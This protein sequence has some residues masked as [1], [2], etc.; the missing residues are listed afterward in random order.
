LPRGEVRGWKDKE[1]LSYP[2]ALSNRIAYLKDSRNLED[3]GDLEYRGSGNNSIGGSVHKKIILLT[4]FIMFSFAQTFAQIAPA[5]GIRKNTPAVHALKNLTIVVAPGKKIEKGTIIVRDG[6]IE[7]AGVNVAIPTDARVWDCAGLTAYAGLIDLYTDLGQPKPRGPGQP[8]PST[9]SPDPPRGS[10]HWNSQ[11]H[12]ELSGAE[13]FLPDKDAAEKFRA[14]GF[15]SVLS[16]PPNGILRGSSALVNLGEGTPNGQT[17]KDN[18]TEDISFSRDPMGDGYPS[19]LMGAIALIRQTFIDANWY[20]DAMRVYAK[21]P[22]QEKPEDDKSLAALEDAAVDKQ[23][24]VFETTDELNILR[25]AKIAREFSLSFWIRGN[26]YEYRR[27]DAVKETNAPIILPV[28]FPDPPNVNTSGEALDAGYEELRHWDFAPENPARMKQAGITFALTTSTLKDVS[29]FRTLVHTAIERGLKADDALASLTTIPAKLVGMEKQLGTLEAGKMANFVLAEGELFGEKTKIR[30]TWIDGVRY[31]VKSP[32]QVEA[33]G[34]WTCSVRIRATKQ[35]TGSLLI[36]GEPEALSGTIG[37]GALMLKITTLT[38]SGKNIALIYPGDSLGYPGVVRMTGIAE[39]S[40][41]T[42]SGELPDGSSF[43]WSARLRTP[44]V[45]PPDTTKKP[46]VQHA[47]FDVVYPEGAFGRKTLP[48][49]P[50]NILV[51]GGYVWTSGP[52]GNLENMDILYAN[53]KVAKIGKDL[54]A[55]KG[56]TIIDAR[57]KHVTA[58][59]IDCHSHTAISEGVNEAGQAI[60]AEVRIADVLDPTDIAIYRELAGGLT[61]ANLLHGSAN[62]IGGQNQVVKLRWGVLPD[63][64]KFEGAPE[65]IKFA[66]GENVKQSNW[67]DRYTTRYPQSRMGVEQIIRD[68]FRAAQDYGRKFEEARKNP[69]MI[70]PR[71]DLELDAIVEILKGTRLVHSHAYRQDEILMLIRIADDFGFTIATFQHVLEGYKIA[72]AIAKHGA[73]ASTFSDWWAYKYEVIDAIPYNGALMHDVGVVVSYNSD[74]DELARR[75]NTESAKG[76]KYG[77]VSEEEALK[78]VTINPAKQLGIDKRVGS[79]EVGKDADF[80]IWSGSPLSTYSMC[81]Q[82]WIDGRKYFDREED[83]VMNAGIQKE[84]AE[85]IQKILKAK[86]PGTGTGIPPMPPKKSSYSCHE[87]E[88]GAE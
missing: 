79:I 3:F 13:Q 12:P 76:V 64:M 69:N 2:I 19:S 74:S 88:G 71:R 50:E 75:L 27:L 17:I 85:L 42:G 82:T 29:K 16:S 67:G 83:R 86:K 45:Q 11:V 51:R 7:S 40:T 59:L 47:S 54:V 53:G 1:I 68:E 28:N 32:P 9:L 61:V 8:S 5:V 60:S 49:Q 14:M 6:I 43:A 38:L 37:R 23:P 44:F 81:E 56:A 35:D 15:T 78:F 4:A 63:Q 21:N 10:A 77:G 18:V 36:G 26:G 31:E 72:E 70:P 25:A 24:V 87:G 22:A 46:E 58:G 65:G 34:A 73:G 33:R 30:E 52:Q 84:R 62:P 20:R 57:G 66:L 39:D 55:P 41:M 80:V 48:E